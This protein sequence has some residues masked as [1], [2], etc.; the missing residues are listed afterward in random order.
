MTGPGVLTLVHQGVPTL[1][2]SN[3]DTSK[4]WLEITTDIV[5]KR[6]SK[7]LLSGFYCWNNF[8]FAL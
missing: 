6:A 8:R 4:I 5:V 2:N 3:S 7:L 1:R